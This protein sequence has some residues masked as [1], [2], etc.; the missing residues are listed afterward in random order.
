[1]RQKSYRERKKSLDFL[2][3]K[4]GSFQGDEEIQSLL[5]KH[6]CVLVSGFLEVSIREIFYGYTEK[7]TNE[8]VAKFVSAQLKHFRSP[9]S[10][11][12]ISLA[13]SFS[14]QWREEL[15]KSIVDDL[16]DALDSIVANRHN[17]AHGTDV[18][19]T[20]GRISA[21]YGNAVKVLSLIETKCC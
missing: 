4:I 2:F 12:V 18:G 17:I 7:K 20:F 6:L 1:M 11:N 3:K 19:I 15:Q 5:T 21:Y 14:E 8:K 10:E 13:G 16:K 9:N